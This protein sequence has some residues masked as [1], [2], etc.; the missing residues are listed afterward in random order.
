MF[1]VNLFA[2]AISTRSLIFEHYHQ[3]YFLRARKGVVSVILS[4]HSR[5]LIYDSWKRR[6]RRRAKTLCSNVTHRSA[7]AQRFK[8]DAKKELKW[9]WLD[10][11]CCFP[12]GVECL[13]IFTRYRWR[14]A[15]EKRRKKESCD[16][17]AAA[18]IIY[19]VKGKDERRKVRVLW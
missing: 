13:S 16:K 18:S 4:V 14:R 17:V 10:C 9:N 11:V 5:Y 19:D 1:Y 3:W 2:F 7:L 12:S 15:R 6:K 8:F